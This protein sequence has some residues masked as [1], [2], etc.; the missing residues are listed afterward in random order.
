M[1]YLSKFKSSQKRP[2]RPSFDQ[3]IWASMGGLLSI[4]SI[5]YITQKMHTPFIIAP[6][7]A[8]CYLLFSVSESPFSQPRSVIGGYLLASILGILFIHQLGI[9]W[10]V[11]TLSTVLSISLMQL[12]HTM[13]PP[14]AGMPLLLML[15]KQMNWHYIFSP[16]LTGTLTMVGIA[17]LFNNLRREGQYPKY[18]F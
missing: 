17:L 2:P 10:W 16:V 7:G 8:T 14:A 5:A 11:M 6:F 1:Y 3:I 9:S 15:T 13:H 4:G 18:W 12:T